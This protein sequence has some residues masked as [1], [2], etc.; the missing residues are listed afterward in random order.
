MRARTL[1]S[2][3]SPNRNT[4]QSRQAKSGHNT[5]ITVQ[6]P[7]EAP[8]ASPKISKS[9]PASIR[10]PSRTSFNLISLITK[11]EALDALSLPFQSPSLQPAPLQVSPRLRKR[12]GGGGTVA[13]H[14]RRLS[15]IFS[16]PSGSGVD[17]EDPFVSEDDPLS[18]R[19]TLFSSSKA[20]AF[21]SHTSKADTRS[22]GKLRGTHK[23]GS[24]LITS[25]DTQK[26]KYTATSNV[27][28]P[29][30]KNEFPSNHK[31]SIR[32]MIKLYDGGS[33]PAPVRKI[34]H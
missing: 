3:S 11:F 33:F 14:F 12:G 34:H 8:A 20:R 10:G 30:V 1:P 23:R 19:E 17:N 29:Y 25:A 27:T 4:Y 26:Q 21:G 22:L 7:G 18:G 31:R 32:D 2:R 24:I 13:G 9:K 16:P 15:T 28:A 6:F 5:S